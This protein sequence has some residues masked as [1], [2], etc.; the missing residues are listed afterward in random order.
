LD[1][2]LNVIGG[3]IAG[4]NAA[5]AAHKLVLTLPSSSKRILPAPAARQKGVFTAGTIVPRSSLLPQV[6]SQRGRRFPAWSWVAPAM[7]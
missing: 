4:I 6:A 3:R 7:H 5:K 1:Y 2:D